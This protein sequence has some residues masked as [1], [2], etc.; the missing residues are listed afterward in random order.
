MTKRAWLLAAAISAAF[1]VSCGGAKDNT[2]VVAPSDM[3]PD[4]IDAD[5]VALLPAQA[6]AYGNF[7][8]RAFFASSSMG[9]QVA[10]VTE[11][12]I[13]IGEEAGFVPSRDVD[14]VYVGSYAVQGFDVVA[15]VVG[16]FDAARIAKVADDKTPTKSGALLV[17]SD[18]AGR[19]IYT[20][21]NVG[22]TILTSK[23]AL[24]GTEQAIHRALDRIHDGT[25]K[26][27]DV[28]KWML[29]TI[30]TPNAAAAV[31]ADFA[32]Q[33]IATAS[34]GALPLPWLKGLKAVRA[35]ADFKPPGMHVASTLS[36]TEPAQA[37]KGGDGLRAVS[38]IVA[39]AA[40]TGA[41]PKIQDLTIETKDADVQCSFALDD[42]GMRKVAAVL[43][44][45]VR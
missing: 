40:I 18:Y 8:A 4:R 28:P 25:A 31:A 20:V 6:V 26:D 1:A 45:A 24:A 39:L 44:Q 38:R 17:A 9:P 30:N 12:I 10:R 11:Q 29:D 36:Y 5:P 23:T 42:E 34:V 43:P 21:N 19:R 33:P 37:T 16:R 2:A 35:L 41:V 32:T 15:V 13:P 3:T 27:G 22:F 14:R 7:D